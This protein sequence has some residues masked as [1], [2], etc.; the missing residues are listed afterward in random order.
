MNQYLIGISKHSEKLI[1]ELSNSKATVICKLLPVIEKLNKKYCFY[2]GEW[3]L[4]SC[5]TDETEIN[6]I[7]NIL[8]GECEFDKEFKF[9]IIRY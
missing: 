2:D 8:F 3:L 4:V 6:D 5:S 7:R 1:K 9:E